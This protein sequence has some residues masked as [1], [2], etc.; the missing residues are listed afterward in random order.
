MVWKDAR[1]ASFHTI[2]KRKRA[3]QARVSSHDENQT[4]SQ[5]TER[6]AK[7]LLP[8][9]NPGENEMEAMLHLYIG[10]TVK[11]KLDRTPLFPEE[12]RRGDAR[13]YPFIPP[14]STH[15]G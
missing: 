1:S 11:A 12:Q 5:R 3:P 14:C 7:S 2:D 6:R 15:G 8:F 9:F 4:H 10:G 13:L